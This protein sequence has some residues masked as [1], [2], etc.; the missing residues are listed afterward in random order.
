M[1]QVS[2]AMSELL[3][4]FDEEG[5]T[6]PQTRRFLVEALANAEEADWRDILEPFVPPEHALRVLASVPGVRTRSLKALPAAHSLAEAEPLAQDFLLA[7]ASGVLAACGMHAAMRCAQLCRGAADALTPL[8]EAGALFWQLRAQAAATAW[9]VPLPCEGTWRQR[10]LA[11]LRP[12]CD[13]IYVGECWFKRYVR[14]GHHADMRKN[15]A[16]LAFDGGRGAT[17]EWLNYRRYLRLLPEVGGGNMMWALVLQDPC[18]RSVAEGALLE[19]I[20]L[21]NHRNPAKPEAALAESSLE[22]PA[23]IGRVRR[24]ICVGRCV[25]RCEDHS[26]AVRYTA[27]DGESYLCFKLGHGDASSFAACLNWVE[28]TRTDENHEVLEFNLGRLPDWK[29]GGLADEDKDHFPA[30]GFRPKVSLEHLL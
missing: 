23:D 2:L 21:E 18:P 13:G 4:V 11:T 29:G 3:D 28:Y 24:R 25:Y 7:L 19:D 12:R 30:L 8:K 5:L 17:S 22:G 16:A 1:A 15:A 6:D 10:F 27:G 20:D 9:R 14:L 26:V